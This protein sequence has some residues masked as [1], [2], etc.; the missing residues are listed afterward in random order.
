[1]ATNFDACTDLH[2]MTKGCSY[3]HGSQKIENLK[4]NLRQ[5]LVFYKLMPACITY[6]V[7]S[8]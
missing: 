2:L 4:Y 5:V 3:H 1:M 6:A 7:D 8:K